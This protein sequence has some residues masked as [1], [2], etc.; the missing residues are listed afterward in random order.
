MEKQQTPLE[1]IGDLIKTLK[2]EYYID[3]PYPRYGLESH[4]NHD[5]RLIILKLEEA[6]EYMRQ[7]AVDLAP[8]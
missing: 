7:R 2:K 3:N 6:E 5:A 1:K 8:D 4:Y